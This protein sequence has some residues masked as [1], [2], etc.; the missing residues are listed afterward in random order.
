MRFAHQCVQAAI[1]LALSTATLV[2]H[3]A[4]KA[5]VPAV[6]A[7]ADAIVPATR[8]Q[9]LLPYTPA[10]ASNRSPDRDWKML[11]RQVGASDSMSLTMGETPGA[12]PENTAQ[13]DAAA[14]KA[15]PQERHRARSGKDLE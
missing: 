14:N 13:V 11:N 2:G 9:S 7:D 1:G 6:S 8:Y 4:D 12:K 10:A 15:A 3:A 5:P